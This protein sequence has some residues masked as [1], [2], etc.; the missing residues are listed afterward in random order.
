MST[1]T[2]ETI[3]AAPVAAK[4]P[5]F[6]ISF[7]FDGFPV[8]AEIEGKADALTAIIERLKGIGATPP[9][10]PAGAP[11]CPAHGSAMKASKKPGS[12][13]CPRQLDDGSYCQHKA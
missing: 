8:V 13:F 5:H 1:A 12:Y 10:K 9:T 4:L 11:L 6:T 3:I 2:N 7:E